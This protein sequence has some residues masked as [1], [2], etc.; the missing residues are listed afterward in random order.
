MKYWY[1]AYGLVISGSSHRLPP[2]VD[3]PNFLPSESV[4]SGVGQRVHRRACLLAH[5]P[6]PGDD[7]APL[8]R[9]ADLQRAAVALVQL[10]VVVGLQQHVAELGVG[11]ALALEPA[12]DRVAV[13]HHVDREVLAD[14]AEELDR[15][16]LAR[17]GQVVLD[18]RAGR[19]IVEVDE[20]LELTAD[21]VGPVG[22]GVG[23]VQGAL[24]GVARVADHAGGAAGQH[25]R[26]MPGLLKPPQR[27]QRNQMAGVQA[28]RGRVESRIDGDGSGGQLGRQRVPV[29][30]LRNQPAPVQL[31]EDVDVPMPSIF[32]Y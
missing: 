21:P 24:A 20:A 3:L 7:V 31:I 13:E 8:I 16:Q 19:R 11:D 10:H 26:P 18:D 32:P 17:P 2:P 14:V 15:R 12:P 6:D 4:T 22:D 5:Q 27:Q 23:G 28:R 25:D 29:G 9:A 1:Q 30:G